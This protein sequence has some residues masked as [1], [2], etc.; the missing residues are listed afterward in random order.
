MK[1]IM[2]ISIFLLAI[3]S[4]SSVSAQDNLTDIASETHA[5]DIVSE[6]EPDSS[7]NSSN[8][9][10]DIG[11][12]DEL[13]YEIQKTNETGLLK[14]E[15]D[16]EYASGSTDGI[17]IDKS[18]T[19]DGQGHTL[20]GKYMS[21]IFN[22][23][24]DYET[25][26][27]VTLMNINF[28][29]GNHDSSGGA[30]SLNENN[31]A[32]GDFPD[33]P[34]YFYINSCNFTDNSAANGGA[35]FSETWTSIY[36]CK[37]ID[38][39][40]NENGGAII[41]SGPGYLTNSNLTDNFAKNGGAVFWNSEGSLGNC[42][43]NNNKA[44]E[45]GGALYWAGGYST[46]QH[47]CTITQSTFNKNSANNGGAIYCTPGRRL[48]NYF[49]LTDSFFINNTA[50]LNG[51]A[52]HRVD[53]SYLID[54]VGGDVINCEF[55]SNC[56]ENGGA[57]Y[58]GGL[59]KFSHNN[60][61][62]N[63]ADYGGAFYANAQLVLKNSYFKNNTALNGGAINLENESNITDCIFIENNATAY[64]GAINASGL[65]ELQIINSIFDRNVAEN[66]GAINWPSS[67]ASRVIL[68]I[69]DC[70]FTN[71]HA[72]DLG[73]AIKGTGFGNFS[74]CNFI[75]NTNY[76]SEIIEWHPDGHSID[77]RI[78]DKYTTYNCTFINNTDYREVNVTINEN[79]SIYITSPKGLH[80]ILD[81]LY[82]G[83]YTQTFKWK[84]FTEY[85]W[86]QDVDKKILNITLN[87]L[88]I[89]L[90]DV[91]VIYA[92]YPHHL[93][94][95]TSRII[96][97]RKNL[98][99]DI[100]YPEEIN[101]DY[102]SYYYSS[103]SR[104]TVKYEPLLITNINDIQGDIKVYVDD[105]YV[106]LYSDFNY[107]EEYMTD[108]DIPTP[109]DEGNHTITLEFM[110][111]KNYKPSN[112]TINFYVGAI[113]TDLNSDNGYISVYLDSNLNGTLIFKA[114][115]IE[116]KRENI[117]PRDFDEYYRMTGIDAVYSCYQTTSFRF[118]NLGKFEINNIE[119]LFEGNYNYYKKFNFNPAYPSDE[120]LKADSK[121]YAPEVTAVYNEGK[122]L[123]VTLKDEKD[124]PIPNADVQI[125]LNGKVNAIKT[126]DEGQVKLTTNGLAPNTYTAK[127]TFNG[128]EKYKNTK[129]QTKI[130]I[131]KAK[132]KLTTPKKTFKH[133]TK[134]KKYTI[135]LKTNKNKAM[136]N[137]KLTLKIN[138]KKYTAK[139]N[140]KG[141][142][143][144]KITKLNK[145]GKY[146]AI[147]T[148]KGNT[149]YKKTTKT[150]KITIK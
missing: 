79:G 57:V 96:D 16:Y 116:Y 50:K 143:T 20:N 127:I 105:T 134:T 76:G 147:I 38:N 62:N 141:K 66:A 30:I 125:E 3:L 12:F 8:E 123:V 58:G 72:N 118:T 95:G 92:P 25:P 90:Y 133:T 75:N 15:K 64:G 28:I 139:T 49:Q 11:T 2:L 26:I 59:T 68:K 103:A 137:T 99:M 84:S 135:T 111:D 102:E 63:H 54:A 61:E 120:V 89:D 82:S 40:A 88:D 122:Y 24:F 119:I 37:L 94:P 138:G 115:G 5:T 110:G 48:T 91:Q 22:I 109:R 117:I 80:G 65:Y 4:L 136:K 18:I 52:I 145:K 29:N 45:D 7:N 71:N 34:N 132:P 74:N 55:I 98:N 78:Y 142:A 1:K 77:A 39:S 9:S 114:N 10:I 87:D 144:F 21:R 13:D 70:N 140:T 31:S 23:Q 146:N 53:S 51:G 149:N 81:V 106:G 130:T 83:R 126:N 107:S 41:F 35:I 60:F 42:N 100:I 27:S 128:N 148:Y 36:N 47:S 97:N 121:L 56:A 93:E 43:F 86:H 6:I 124:N 19:I 113:T 44:E 32:Y 33:Y 85:Y 69:N 46:S 108:Y 73:G 14:L 104:N 112:K 129:T 17:L 150:T 101:S 131:Q 67:D